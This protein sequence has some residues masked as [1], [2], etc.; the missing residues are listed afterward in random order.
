[1]IREVLKMCFFPLGCLKG[2]VGIGATISVVIALALLAGTVE[3]LS[4]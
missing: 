1:M 4:K 3:E 2:I